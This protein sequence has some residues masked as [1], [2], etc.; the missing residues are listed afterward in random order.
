MNR[1]RGATHSY[2]QIASRYAAEIGG[3]LAGKSLNRAVLTAFAEMVTG[4]ARSSTAG[5]GLG[6]SR[7]TS[8][9]RA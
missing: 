4:P 5:R 7:P 8:G 2:D 3:E 9:S 6:T 1:V